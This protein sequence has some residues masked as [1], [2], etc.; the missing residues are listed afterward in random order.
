MSHEVKTINPYTEE[1]IETFH[2]LGKGDA[3]AMVDRAHEAFKSWKKTSLEERSKIIHNVANELRYRKDELSTLMSTEMGKLKAEGEQEVE[4]C[5]AICEY[6][7]DNAKEMLADEQKNFKDGDAFITY[8]PLGVVLSIQPWNFPLYQVLRNSIPNIMGGNVS[9]TK[10]A[11]STWGTARAIEEIFKSAGLP[12]NVFT[13]LYVEDDIIESVIENDKVQ[14]VSFTGS[15]G[16]G[17]KVAAKAG[18]ELKKCVLEL[19]GS[20]AYLVLADADIDMAA[21][22][23]AKGRVGNNGQTCTA[24]K[25][26]VVVDEVY[27]EFRDKLIANMEGLKLGDPLDKS[28]ELGPLVRKDILDELEKQVKESVKHGAKILTGGKRPERTGFFFESTILEDVK[29]GMPAYDEELFGPVASLIRAKD[30]EDA[31]RIANDT[32]FGLGSGIFSRDVEKATQIARER[33]DAGISNVNGFNL[34][35]PNLPF[36]GIKASGYGREHARFGFHEFMNIKTVMVA[37]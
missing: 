15:M 28:T 27:D 37:K 10:H 22:I 33:L 20:D 31:I 30:T 24:A 6:C 19:G 2:L 17:K 3:L 32:I 7:A 29:P 23:C 25:R 12:E 5:A 26:F 21:K 18:E 16:A 8:Q 14:A 13:H 4:L 1:A 11:Q 36:G 35:K 34:A 9:L